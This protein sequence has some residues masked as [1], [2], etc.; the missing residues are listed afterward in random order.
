VLGSVFFFRRYEIIIENL[1][2]L[3]MFHSFAAFF[4]VLA[5]G[6]M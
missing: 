6:F 2:I 1:A 5:T 3:G 4:P